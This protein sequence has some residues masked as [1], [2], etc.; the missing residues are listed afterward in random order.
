MGGNWIMMD[1]MLVR[2]G[3]SSRKAVRMRVIK[4][5]GLP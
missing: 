3:P 5:A 4:G 1:Q 2:T